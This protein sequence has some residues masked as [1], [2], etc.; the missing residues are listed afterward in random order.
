M[1]LTKVGRYN[2]SPHA[3][4]AYSASKG[5]R[6]RLAPLVLQYQ[7]ANGRGFPAATQALAG[8]V[9]TDFRSMRYCM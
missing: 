4:L 1:A 6:A 7:D 9:H 3:R 8:A 5:V 2:F